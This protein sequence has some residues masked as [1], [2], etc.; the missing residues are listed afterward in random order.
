MQ[1]HA[2]PTQTIIFNTNACGRHLSPSNQTRTNSLFSLTLC[3]QNH[4]VPFAVHHF[5]QRAAH[6][7]QMG[8]RNWFVMRL[9][10]GVNSSSIHTLFGH[11]HALSL[12]VSRA[13]VMEERPEFNLAYQRAVILEGL[14]ARR[15]RQCNEAAAIENSLHA[16]IAD[17]FFPKVLLQPHL[18]PTRGPLI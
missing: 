6:C 7:K 11:I 4:S 5:C 9:A 17:G 2:S 3:V 16:Y 18:M 1:Q 14:T 8:S 15:E 12:T 13:R 10:M